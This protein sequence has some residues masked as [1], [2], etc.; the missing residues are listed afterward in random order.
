M[1]AHYRSFKQQQQTLLNLLGIYKLHIEAN[2]V[3]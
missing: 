1:T 3:I 2:P